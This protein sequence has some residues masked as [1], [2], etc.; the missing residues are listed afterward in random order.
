[1]TDSRARE[2]VN[3][4]FQ[5]FQL[6]GYEQV[7]V[8]DICQACQI[9]KPTFYKYVSSKQ[10]I[11]LSLFKREEEFIYPVALALYEG[12]CLTRALFKGL[13]FNYSVALSIG[14]LLM[15]SCIHSMM[16]KGSPPLSCSDK[17]QELM[18]RILEDL[19]SSGR[20]RSRTDPETLY[21]IL[22]S[23]EQGM[24]LKWIACSG[25]FDL[26]R[27]FKSALHL[28]LGLDDSPETK[29]EQDIR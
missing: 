15:V 3:T 19:I 17:M 8:L 5:L 18:I 22:C 10:N 9:T 24:F 27:E 29:L 16:E 12:G 23:I 6:R 2:I 28:I 11:L 14:P 1:M 20:I 7:S 4:A 26:N 25:E 21:Q 13:T